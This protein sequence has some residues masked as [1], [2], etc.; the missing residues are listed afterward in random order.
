MGLLESE[1]RQP[2]VGVAAV[3]L[4]GNQVLLGKRRGAHGATLWATPGGHLEF[5]EGIETCAKREL[6]EETGLIALSVRLGP[7]V[8]NVIENSKHYVTLFTFIE[9]FEGEL[10][11]LEPDK[12]EGWQWFDWDLLPTP[13]FPSILSLL[14]KVSTEKLKEGILV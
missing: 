4:R 5:G 7:W 8:N 3:A 11:L 14:E 9:E 1:K 12:C 10:Q 6:R 2:R 13:L